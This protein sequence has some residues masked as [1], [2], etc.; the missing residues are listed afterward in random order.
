[1]GEEQYFPELITLEARHSPDLLEYPGCCL[2]QSVEGSA[3]SKGFVPTHLRDER[4][5]TQ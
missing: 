1:M 3:L 2:L 5:A 4:M